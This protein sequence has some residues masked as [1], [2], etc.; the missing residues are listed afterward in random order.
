MS[1]KICLLQEV[2]QVSIQI[3]LVD[4]SF[5]NVW[6]PDRD[7]HRATD[8]HEIHISLSHSFK[9]CRN[10]DGIGSASTDALISLVEARA[11][12]MTFRHS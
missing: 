4:L 2:I 8:Q 9:N 1:F 5:V 12:R 3:V 10:F 7:R 11:V 6:K